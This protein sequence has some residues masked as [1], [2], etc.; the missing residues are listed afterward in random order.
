MQ[1]SNVSERIRVCLNKAIECERRALLVTED[2][3]R[4]TYLELAH[5]W[6]DI[7][8]QVHSLHQTSFNRE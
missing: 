8:Q 3:H 7:A 6:R 4:K 5:L 1:Q 2:A